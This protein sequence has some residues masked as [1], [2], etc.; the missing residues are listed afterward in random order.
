MTNPSYTACNHKLTLTNPP[1]RPF[2]GLGADVACRA[3][4][5]INST[6][7]PCSG[8]CGF[9]KGLPGGFWLRLVHSGLCLVILRAFSIFR[10]MLLGL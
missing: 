8:F 6:C 2:C 5:R 3:S 10:G 7:S 1:K 4:V 9:W